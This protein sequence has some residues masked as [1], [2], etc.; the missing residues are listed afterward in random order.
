LVEVCFITNSKEEILVKKE[1]FQTAVANAILKGVLNFVGKKVET[2][3]P[4]KI[5]LNGKEYE[6]KLE[7]GISYMKVKDVAALL[8][9]KAVM[10]NGIVSVV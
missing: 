3:E 6:G 7:G 9:K 10:N 2:V 4:V 5:E 8:D 1:D